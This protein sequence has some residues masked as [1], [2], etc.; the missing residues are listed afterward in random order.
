MR[1]KK[2]IIYMLSMYNVMFVVYLSYSH[3]YTLKEIFGNQYIK[4]YI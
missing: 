2:I 3:N 4:N 1:I